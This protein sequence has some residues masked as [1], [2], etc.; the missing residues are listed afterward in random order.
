MAVAVCAGLSACKP[1]PESAVGPDQLPHPKA[2]LWHWSSKSGAG[3][4]CLAGHVPSAL[5]ERPGCPVTRRVRLADG[6]FLVEAACDGAAATRT[7][8][9]ASGDYASAFSLDVTIGDVS[10]HVAYRYLGPCPPGHA[11][12]DGP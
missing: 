4:I 12:D 9:K 6:A 8:A 5:A 10:D 1:S 7:R 2:G 11:T 3:Q